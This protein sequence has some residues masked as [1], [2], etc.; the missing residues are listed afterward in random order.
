MRTV[1][2]TALALPGLALA[3]AGLLHPAHLTYATSRTW[4]LLHVLG[5]FV[6]PLVGV[7]LMALFRGRRDP[8]AVLVVLASFGYAVAYTALDVISGLAAGYVTWRLG[9]GQARPDEVRYLFAVGGPIGQWGSRALVLAAVLVAL[10]A[11]GR[12]RLRALP[13]VLLPVGAVLVHQHHIFVPL[14]VTGMLLVGLAT[15]WL[16]YL[17]AEPRSGSESETESESETGS[18]PSACT[19]TTAPRSS[20]P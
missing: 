11:L 14:G 17:V 10:D 2:A 16:G 19:P 13:G 18:G 3:A 20:G 1:R 9:P 12:R 7:A 4:W 5:M 6:F 15:G 8:V